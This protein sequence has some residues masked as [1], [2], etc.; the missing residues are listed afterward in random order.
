MLS[1]WGIILTKPLLLLLASGASKRFG[2]GDKL[3]ASLNGRPLASFAARLCQDRTDIHRLAVVPEN[4]PERTC[5][6]ENFGWQVIENPDAP[7]GMASSVRTGVQIAQTL[8]ASSVIIA[9]ADM[10]FVEDIHV[11]RL[12]AALQSYDA[13]MSELE[14]QLMPPAAFKSTAFEDL[15]ALKGD[16]GARSVFKRLSLTTT[17][18]LDRRA[19]QDIDTREMLDLLQKDAFL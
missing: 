11:Q 4:S 14:G 15:F 7:S 8:D 2:V 16:T 1:T 6:M 5:L 9:L 12:Q 17:V 3:L 13:A 10:P 19:A 18:P